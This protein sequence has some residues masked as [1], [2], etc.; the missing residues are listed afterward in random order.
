MAP[1]T[2]DHSFWRSELY[3]CPLSSMKCSIMIIIV[4]FSAIRCI[5]AKSSL[6]FSDP[7]QEVRS[8]EYFPHHFHKLMSRFLWIIISFR[9]R[10]ILA[11]YLLKFSITVGYPWFKRI[12]EQP[13]HRLISRSDNQ[14]SRL[15][16]GGEEG[17]LLAA[18]G[19]Q[20]KKNNCGENPHTT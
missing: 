15:V 6:L 11:V 20:Q 8:V 17:T 14:I 18:D 7:N 1:V 4:L 13:G 2:H 10:E 5:R 3:A 16:G 19:G 12:V 9:K